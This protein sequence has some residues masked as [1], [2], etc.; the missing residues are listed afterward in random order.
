MRPEDVA[1][2]IM[3]R[4]KDREYVI[5]AVPHWCRWQGPRTRPP[6]FSEQRTRAWW[7]GERR[8]A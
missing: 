6:L 7:N 1:A 4:V 2:E 8:S 5:R 3:D